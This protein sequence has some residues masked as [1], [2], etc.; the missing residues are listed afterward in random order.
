MIFTNILLVLL[1]VFTIKWIE[2]A[3]DYVKMR[4]DSKIRGFLVEHHYQ[5]M[6]LY[7]LLTIIDLIFLSFAVSAGN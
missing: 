3:V 6:N 7:G 4:D 1:I 5:L 2:H